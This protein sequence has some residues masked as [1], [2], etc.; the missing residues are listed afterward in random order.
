FNDRILNLNDELKLS[1]MAFRN[2]LRALE[3][4][5][6]ESLRP[7]TDSSIY[8]QSLLLEVLILLF[9]S[10]SSRP[11]I[12]KN[13][14]DV[15]SDFR[16]LAELHFRENRSLAVYAQTLKVSLKTLAERCRETLGTSPKAVILN[17]KVLEA[18]RL[19]AFTAM[20]VSEVGYGLGF[21]DPNYFSRFFKEETGFSPQVF[22]DRSK[23]S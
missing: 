10:G 18:K 22:R 20:P 7:G 12:S 23:K 16:K 17:R 15:A 13:S 1:P 4:L 9:R 3:I 14:S 2:L 19:L 8:R 21:E 6:E 5:N 11:A